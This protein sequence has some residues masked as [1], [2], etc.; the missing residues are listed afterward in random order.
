MNNHMM[1]LIINHLVVGQ[2]KEIS[3]LTVESVIILH[4]PH[5]AFTLMRA[6][7]NNIS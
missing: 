1:S 7:H 4:P 2:V 6:K 3:G 5:T